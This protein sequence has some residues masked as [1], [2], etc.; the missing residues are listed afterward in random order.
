MHGPFAKRKCFS[1]HSS[2]YVKG[3]RFGLKGNSDFSLCSQCH[4]APLV[5]R[6]M[7]YQHGPFAARNCT[8][9]HDP[10]EGN[11][12][13]LLKYEPKK[14]LCLACH[15]DKA[16]EF[17]S[18]GYRFHPILSAKGC[19]I[20]HDPHASD[21]PKQLYDTPFKVCISCHPRFGKIKKGHPI[22]AHP[23][24][25]PLIP[26]TNEKLTCSSCHN[27]HGSPYESLLYAPR[28]GSR[29]CLKCHKY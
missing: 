12:R 5:W 8:A 24:V 16:K 29:V 1:C 13:F 20:C 10:H 28:A 19:V 15:R 7:L 17:S 18:E 2:G 9:C 26:G 25:G 4:F 3:V 21:Y 11:F 27:P 14:G 22:V 6:K 23:V